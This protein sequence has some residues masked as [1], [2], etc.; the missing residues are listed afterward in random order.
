MHSARQVDEDDCEIEEQLLN[1]YRKPLGAA[2][3]V[4]R[5]KRPKRPRDFDEFTKVQ[6]W[7]AAAAAR[8]V[9]APALLIC[10]RLLHLAWKAKYRSFTVP[11]GW[12][13]ERGISKKT[14]ARVLRRLEKAK[15][16]TIDWHQGKAFRITL[17][18]L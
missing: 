1:S 3:A 5:R 16:I 12:L 6:I 17:N 8:A 18:V 10:V 4:K 9:R 2:R 13:E 11:N 15:L 7:W 14:K